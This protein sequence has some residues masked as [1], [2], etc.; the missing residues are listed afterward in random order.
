MTKPLV[1]LGSLAL[2]AL[3]PLLASCSELDNCPDAASEPIVIESGATDLAALFYESSRWD[4]PRQAFPAKTCLRFKHGLEATP[5]IVNTYVSFDSSGGDSS[6]NAGNQG[7]IECVDDDEIVIRNDTCEDSF[8]IRVAAHASG[9]SH[10][11]THCTELD[12]EGCRL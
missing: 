9:S 12:V 8:Y 1:A 7:R 11:E 3:L 10:A 2:L 6:E 4:E 5:E